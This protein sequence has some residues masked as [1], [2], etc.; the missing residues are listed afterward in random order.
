MPV[1][2][3]P[4][5]PTTLASLDPSIPAQ[6]TL[7]VITTQW[8]DVGVVFRFQMWP[9]CDDSTACP[10]SGSPGEVSSAFTY[11]DAI[12]ASALVE[13][14]LVVSQA[15]PPATVV[16]VAMRETGT[17]MWGYTGS[18]T[19]ADGGAGIPLAFFRPNNSLM[20]LA[21]AP[22]VSGAWTPVNGKAMFAIGFSHPEPAQLGYGTQAPCA[23]T[24]GNCGVATSYD[25]QRSAPNFPDQF[26]TYSQ[27][28]EIVYRVVFPYFTS[29]LLAGDTTETCVPTLGIKFQATDPVYP[30]G[31]WSN[32]RD[33]IAQPWVVDKPNYLSPTNWA[34]YYVLEPDASI[35]DRSPDVGPFELAAMPGQLAVVYFQPR[36]KDIDTDNAPID[37]SSPAP[38]R[39]SGHAQLA[40]LVTSPLQPQQN[41]YFTTDGYD[42]N[43]GGFGPRNPSVGTAQFL[44]T[45]PSFTWVTGAAVIPAGVVVF[46]DNIGDDTNTI[47]IQDAHDSDADVGHIIRNNIAGQAVPGIIVLSVWETFGRG[48]ARPV[49]GS[50]FVTAALSDQ[51]AGDFPELSPMLTINR[52]RFVGQNIYGRNKIFDNRGLPGT[53]QSPL[54]NSAT[55]EKLPYGTAVDTLDMPVFRHMSHFAW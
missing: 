46:I 11:A 19:Y 47:T 40:M 4:S 31:S 35:I 12:A 49:L 2:W 8:I 53:V 55:F 28:W 1:L 33:C 16:V 27:P 25:A 7:N 34:Y 15:I 5:L 36:Y 37:N 38:Q 23:S 43:N 10:A 30:S 24:T 48:S 52:Y 17:A 44:H 45:Q 54:I 18:E 14:D 29:R 32:L 20:C 39:D 50:M 42:S 41:I 6:Y 26:S 51:Y 3:Q 13:F 22:T 9:G 21:F